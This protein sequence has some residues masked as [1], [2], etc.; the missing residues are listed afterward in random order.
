LDALW[1]LARGK[2]GGNYLHLIF[3]TFICECYIDII[4][5]LLFPQISFLSITL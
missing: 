3:E 2:T 4:S 1:V 5:L